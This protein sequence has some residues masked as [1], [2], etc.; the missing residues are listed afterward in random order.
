ML[1]FIKIRFVQLQQAIDDLESAIAADEATCKQLEGKVKEMTA[2]R[3]GA[4]AVRL[5]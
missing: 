3:S 1:A 2:S 4:G 5:Q